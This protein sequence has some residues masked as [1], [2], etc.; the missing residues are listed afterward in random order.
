MDA[1]GPG[2]M[3]GL[4]AFAATAFLVVA[5]LAPPEVQRAD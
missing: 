5:A 2:G 4:V 1:L 3:L